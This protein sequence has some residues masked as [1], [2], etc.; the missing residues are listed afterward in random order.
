MRARA[1]HAG[2]GAQPPQYQQPVQSQPPAKIRRAVWSIPPAFPAHR[3][4][5]RAGHDTS[6]IASALAARCLLADLADSRAPDWSALLWSCGWLVVMVSYAAVRTWLGC[7]LMMVVSNLRV[8]DGATKVLT[9]SQ[10]AAKGAFNAA[11]PSGKPGRAEPPE[12]EA[13]YT[14]LEAVFGTVDWSDP[15][16]KVPGLDDGAK[17]DEAEFASYIGAHATLSDS[18]CVWILNSPLRGSKSLF[19]R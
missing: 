12:K 1:T 2:Y 4:A 14:E 11:M 9:P 3:H 7:M 16:K 15:D 13:V 18:E 17:L 19:D 10:A 6:I 5:V 8:S